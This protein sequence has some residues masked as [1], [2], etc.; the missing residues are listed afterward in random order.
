MEQIRN[1]QDG[2]LDILVNDIWG[3]DPLAEWGTP[4][5]EH[6][7][8]NGLHMQRLAV[9]THLTTTW[10][11]APLMVARR[12]GLIVEVTDGIGSGYRGS[13]F[14]DLAKA[15]VLR[16]AL[17]TSEELRPIGVAVVAVSPGFL[18][19]EAMLDHFGVTESNWRAAV[20]QDPHFVASETPRYLGR[21][22]AALAAEADL[23]AE[24][25]RAFGSWDLAH[26][27][28]LTDVDGGRPDW[29]TYFREVVLGA[30][31]AS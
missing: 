15:A 31:R 2:Q 24:S 1:E 20:A 5:W 13:L 8:D 27:Y 19:S 7:L 25:G 17:G 23:V 18:R 26:R 16:L 29:G 4:F 14:Y 12:S 22:V 28:S 3:G 10:H 9:D 6:N 11:A 30:S 21:G